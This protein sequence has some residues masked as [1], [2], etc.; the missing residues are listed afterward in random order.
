MKITE[1]LTRH[2]LKNNITAINRYV[3]NVYGTLRYRTCL[4]L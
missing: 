4:L 2:R 3:D 1:S